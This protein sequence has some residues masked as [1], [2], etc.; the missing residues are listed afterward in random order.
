MQTLRELKQGSH[1]LSEKTK[2]KIFQIKYVESIV[3]SLGQFALSSYIG[4]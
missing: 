4:M 1:E 2:I 3:E